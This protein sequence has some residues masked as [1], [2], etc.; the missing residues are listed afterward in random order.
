MS[1]PKTARDRRAPR[2]PARVTPDRLERYAVWYLE[3]WPASRAR[4]E[5]QLARR[6]ADSTRRHGPPPADPEEAAAWI[7]AAVRKC[8][9]AGLLDDDA[10]ARA[11]ARTLFRR[12]KSRR[13]ITADLTRRGLPADAVAA[14]LRDL[15]AQEDGPAADLVAAVLLARR[16]R[17][18][19]FRTRAPQDRD[20][21]RALGALARAGFDRML[22]HRVLAM[23]RN[24]AEAILAEADPW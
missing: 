2:P 5:S 6:L 21:A 4:L 3:R 17:L 12:G 13:A 9:A 8:A 19:P 7:A 14:A 1:D 20:D 24:E 18:G 15:A 10:Y 23:T 22:A 16:R 11:R